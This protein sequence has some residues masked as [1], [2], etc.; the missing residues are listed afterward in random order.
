VA[1]AGVGGHDLKVVEG[2]LGPPQQLVALLVTGELQVGVDV[3]GIGSGEDVGDHRVIDDQFRRD[4]RVDRAGIT[5]ERGHRVSHRHQVDHTGHTGE[6]LHQHPRRRKL[7]LGM[8]DLLRFPPREG[9]DLVGGDQVPV[10]VTQ[11]VL[12]QH[13]QAVGQPRGAGDGVQAVDAVGLL[14]HRQRAACTETVVTHDVC[15]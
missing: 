4:Q 12:Q 10:L 11:Q 15:S 2:L 14:A 5:P 13:L 6:V 8:A 9:L 1:D 7:D 3:V